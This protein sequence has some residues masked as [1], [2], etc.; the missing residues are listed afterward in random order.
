MNQ[1]RVLIVDDHA[2][3][4]EG[5]RMILATEH[6][7]QIVGEAKDGL[8]AVDQAEKLQPDIILMDLVMPIGGL[9]AIAKIKRR[10]PNIKIIVLTTFEDEARVNAAMV[11]GADGY[12][13]KEADGEAVLNAIQAVQSGETPLHP[14]VFQHIIK[15]LSKQIGPSGLN[16]LTDREKE[17]LQWIAKGLSNRIIAEALH[18]SEGT[19]KIHVKNIFNKLN[20]SN[21]TEAAILAAQMEFDVSDDE[22]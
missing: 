10:C 9:E 19:V 14:R 4:R 18:L 12:L 1:V 5:M 22:T 11:A 8:E 7:F 17:V 16:R 15:G 20:V 21:R 3:V 13:L 2:V 6:T